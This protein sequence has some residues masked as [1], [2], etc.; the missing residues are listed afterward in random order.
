MSSQSSHDKMLSSPSVSSYGPGESD[1]E[2]YDALSN[3]PYTNYPFVTGRQYEDGYGPGGYL[4]IGL[5]EV[6]LERYKVV[7]KLGH[8]TSSTTWL[9]RDIWAKAWRALRVLTDEASTDNP[10]KVLKTALR[11]SRIS[12]RKEAHLLLPIDEF[13]VVG[14]G[15]NEHFCFVFP[16]FGPNVTRIRTILVDAP[17]IDRRLRKLCYQVVE[18]VSFLHRHGICHGGK[19]SE[20]CARYNHNSDI[21]R[22]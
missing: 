8:G 13:T 19:S 17:D 18:A 15:D 1:T 3:V 21:N 14:H 6:F 11:R 9:C 12:N 22:P 4:A 5:G 2:G 7:H 10:Y 20:T 16:F